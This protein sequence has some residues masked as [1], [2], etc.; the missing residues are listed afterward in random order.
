[1]HGFATHTFCFPFCR[2]L[3]GHRHDGL[4]RWVARELEY[5]RRAGHAPASVAAQT[6]RSVVA[7]KG[8]LASRTSRLPVAGLHDSLVRIVA[9]TRRGTNSYSHRF[10]YW[11]VTC[12]GTGDGVGDL[13]QQRVE[14][15]HL[16]TVEGVIFGDLDA[17]LSVLAHAQLTLRIRQTECPAFKDVAHELFGDGI[18][19]AIDMSVDIEKVEDPPGVPRMVLTLNG[20]WL[21]YKKF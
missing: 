18:M 20:K 7:V 17:F 16:R 14:N 2:L 1:M 13:V 9:G 10:P 21:Q 8:L 4:E 6:L 3:H 11:A 5:Q 15:R 19:S 12:L